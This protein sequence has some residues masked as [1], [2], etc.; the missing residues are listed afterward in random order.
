MSAL[1]F[2]C[3]GLNSGGDRGRLDMNAK[4]P[5]CQTNVP[6]QLHEGTNDP[7]E[8]Y[9][10]HGEC[11]GSYMPVRRGLVYRGLRLGVAL[12]LVGMLVGGVV[13]LT[14]TVER[15]LQP[16][17]PHA[18]VDTPM[19]GKAGPMNSPGCNHSLW[20]EDWSFELKERRFLDRFLGGS[21][22]EYLQYRL[23]PEMFDRCYR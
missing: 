14:N 13:W 5:V 7:R 16:S 15:H 12:I 2:S 22:K 9:S 21:Y 10:L 18:E 11:R 17:L 6:S 3:N 23:T 1:R 8:V 19:S 20:M 4:C